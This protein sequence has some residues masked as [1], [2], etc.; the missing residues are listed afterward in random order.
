MTIRMR[1]ALKRG[2][3]KRRKK[4]K[5]V[6]DND[7][8]Q[9]IFPHSKWNVFFLSHFLLHS[10][11]MSNILH[12][13]ACLLDWDCV[14]WWIDRLFYIILVS[15]CV[16][17]AMSFLPFCQFLCNFYTFMNSISG[18][19]CELNSWNQLQNYLFFTKFK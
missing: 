14:K 17:A 7:K 4:D 2:K 15:C 19:W 1:R 16:Y 12:W 18:W 10:W 11:L 3:R 8:M 6:N 13:L 9:S 5:S